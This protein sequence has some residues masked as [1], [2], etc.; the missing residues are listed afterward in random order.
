MFSPSQKSWN[1]FQISFVPIF[2]RKL[3]WLRFWVLSHTEYDEGNQSD[4]PTWQG[5][6]DYRCDEGDQSDHLLDT[7]R[8]TM[9]FVVMKVINPIL[10]YL[11]VRPCLN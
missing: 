5:D 1:L 11:T 2:L 7:D 8:V 10:S 9:M 6:N 4:H 3:V